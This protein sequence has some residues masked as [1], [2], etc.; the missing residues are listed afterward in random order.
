LAIYKHVWGVEDGTTEG[1]LQL[2]DREGREAM[3]RP[4]LNPAPKA[5]IRLVNAFL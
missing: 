5:L 1:Q 2:A 4:D 3:Q